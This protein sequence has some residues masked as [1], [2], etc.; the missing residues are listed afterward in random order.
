MNVLCLFA[1]EKQER[2]DF[3]RIEEK[4]KGFQKV[5]LA[6]TLPQSIYGLDFSHITRG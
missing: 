3:K 2:Q 4:L 6:V 5:L 1:Y